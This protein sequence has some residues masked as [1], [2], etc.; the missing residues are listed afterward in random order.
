VEFEPGKASSFF[1]LF[2]MEEEL[3]AMLGGRK[4]NLCTPEDLTQQVCDIL[5]WRNSR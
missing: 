2:D 4:V 1:R 5:R 3:S